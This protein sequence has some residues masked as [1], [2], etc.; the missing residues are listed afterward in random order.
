MKALFW[1]ISSNETHAVLGAD[2]L[3]LCGRKLDM[4]LPVLT[5]DPIVK[6]MCSSSEIASV[7]VC[8]ECF[9]LAFQHYGDW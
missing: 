9:D 7:K 4:N 2:D 1:I 6:T 5:N 8:Q 3:S